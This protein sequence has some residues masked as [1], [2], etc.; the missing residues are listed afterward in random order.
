MV[1]LFIAKFVIDVSNLRDPAAEVRHLSRQL[2]HLSV[3]KAITVLC[4]Q[5]YDSP[6]RHG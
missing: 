1:Y 4:N 2:I 3:F 5:I 6:S